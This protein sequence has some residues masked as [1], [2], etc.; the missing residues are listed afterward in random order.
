M[1]R[2]MV[3]QLNGSSSTSTTFRLMLLALRSK[4]SPGALAPVLCGAFIKKGSLLDDWLAN[5]SS[6]AEPVS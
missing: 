3:T 6:L 5:V 4:T 2:E 1:C